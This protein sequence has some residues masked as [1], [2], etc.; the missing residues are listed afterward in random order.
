[1]LVL[2]VY[3]E[4]NLLAFLALIKLPHLFR[5]QWTLANLNPFNFI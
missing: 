5:L 3:A 4:S 1:M 2:Y